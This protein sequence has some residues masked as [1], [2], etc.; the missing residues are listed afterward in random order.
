MS[1][2]S[3]GRYQWLHG[4]NPGKP[5][6][7]AT[8]PFLGLGTGGSI[9]N[10]MGL[11]L[12]V[13]DHSGDLAIQHAARQALLRRQYDLLRAQLAKAPTAVCTPPRCSA[14]ARRAALQ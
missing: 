7:S 12:S 6:T 4:M 9:T 13:Q 11:A 3:S 2:F 10:A 8:A 5:S 14:V 1:R